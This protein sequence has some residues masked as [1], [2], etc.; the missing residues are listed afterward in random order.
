MKFD[1]NVSAFSPIQPDLYEAKELEWNDI[2]KTQR[3]DGEY[4]YVMMNNNDMYDR[5]LKDDIVI[6]KIQDECP[7]DG[8]ALLSVNNTVMLKQIKLTD[9]KFIL[10]NLNPYDDSESVFDKNEVTILGVPVSVMR[11]S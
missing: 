3:K 8:D 6:I 7:N 9:N 11:V 1:N 4:L 10:T 5:Y 2:P